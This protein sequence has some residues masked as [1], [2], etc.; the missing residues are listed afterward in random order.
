MS[1]ARRLAT[2]TKQAF[3][4][5]E[6]W[7]YLII[8]IALF[9]AGAAVDVGD[10]EGTAFPA[11]QVWLYA[12][13]LT[14]GYMISRGL[15]KSGSHDPYSETPPDQAGEGAPLGDRVRAAA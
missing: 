14:I 13:L 9:I 12:T 15:S 1:T 11:D 4:T 8:L 6:F 10:G 7:A 3:K 5:T 2:E